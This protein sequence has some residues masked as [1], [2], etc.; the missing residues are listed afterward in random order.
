M[1]FVDE[2]TFWA[3]FRVPAGR[4]LRGRTRHAGPLLGSSRENRR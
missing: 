2:A 4:G 3:T 1:T